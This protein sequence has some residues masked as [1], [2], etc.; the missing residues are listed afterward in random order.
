MFESICLAQDDFLTGWTDFGRLAE[1]LVFYQKVHIITNGITFPSLI[2]VCGSD[3]VLELCRIGN[4]HIHYAEN[5]PAVGTHNISTSAERHGLVCVKAENQNFQNDTLKLFEEYCGPSGKGL[6][7]TLRTFS[8]VVKPFEYQRSMLDHVQSDVGDT[9]YI[10]ACIRGILASLAPEYKQPSPLI[11]DVF[12]EADARLRIETNIDFV[13][14]NASYHK[15][16][17]PQHSSLSNA[18]LMARVLTARGSLEIA[19]RL[20]SDLLLGPMGQVIAANKIGSLLQLRD[21]H[22]ENLDRFTEFVVDGSRAISE[23]VNSRRHGFD[24]VLKLV[25]EAQKFKEW[26]RKQDESADLCAEYCREVSRVDWADRLPHKSARWLLI[27]AFSLAVGMPASPAVAVVAGLGISAADTFLLDKL[28][29]GWKPN[30]FVE[31][32]LKKFIQEG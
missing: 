18:Y 13:A 19:S 12:V 16:V 5:T 9:A 1:A 25:L 11:F 26:L 20:S 23:A 17:S 3:V 27:N 15:C 24:E 21:R 4:L 31:G 8:K 2:R 10:R 22:Q 30:Q 6:N 29:K 14:A 28:L 7:R 32:P